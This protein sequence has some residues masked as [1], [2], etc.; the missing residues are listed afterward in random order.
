MRLEEILALEIDEINNCCIVHGFQRGL[1]ESLKEEVIIPDFYYEYPVVRISEQAFMNCDSLK[2][3]EIPNTVTYIGFS[4]FK[5]SGLETIKLPNSLT[6]IR[7]ETFAYCRKLT[8]IILPSSII[9]IGNKAF[10]RCKNLIN[11]ELSANLTNIEDEAFLGCEK[12]EEIIFPQRVLNIGVN[13]FGGCSN[14]INI[15][16]EQGNLNYCSIDGVLYGENG[17]TLIKYPQGRKE[18]SFTIL[19]EVVT[20]DDAA[21]TFCS[22]LKELIIEE[23]SQLSNIKSLAFVVCKI[24]V[25]INNSDLKLTIGSLKNGRIAYDTYII[26]DK[27]GCVEYKKGVT[28]Y[29]KKDD[30]VFIKEDEKYKLIDY[31]G[32]EKTITLPLNINNSEYLITPIKTVNSIIIPHGFTKINE[33]AFEGCDM[34]K[35]IEI[36]NTITCIEEYAFIKTTNLE[37]IYYNGTIADFCK[38]NFNGFY[39]APK[40]YA[41]NIYMLDDNGEYQEV[42]NI[43]IPDHQTTIGAFQFS[44][45][46]KIEKIVLPK[47]IKKIAYSAFIGIYN[48]KELYYDGTI[49]DWCQIEF[50]DEA[51]N[52]L[53]RALKVYMKNENNEYYE[54]TELVIPNTITSIGKNQFYRL[55]TITKI[56]LPETIKTIGECAF[57]KCVAVEEI[58][59][60][61]KLKT[62]EK[63]AFQECSSLRKIVIPSSVE[64][65]KMHAFHGCDNLKEVLFEENS[66]LKKLERYA[67]AENN[68]LE[69]FVLPNSVTSMSDHI[70]FECKSLEKVTV[71]SNLLILDKATFKGC[72]ELKEIEFPENSILTKIGVSVFEECINLQKINIPNTVSIIDKNAFKRCKSLKEITI[73]NA[74]IKIDRSAFS[75]CKVEIN[76]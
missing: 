49:A 52:P 38:I 27:Y 55:K 42:T 31:I 17:K 28:E 14:L 23:N 48:V 25:I 71:S 7:S 6:E 51:A 43:V 47:S 8:S 18:T 60:S 19:K 12:L 62:I 65:I 32:E 37:N 15:N 1:D 46:D 39:S 2:R 74:N 75:S 44:K 50:L 57:H 69:K 22:Y 24:N 61:N 67:F 63:Y 4:A 45:F 33:K 56:V 10:W 40:M 58:K 20:I 76:Q 11:I 26:V 54:L 72:Q 5:D 64:T 53:G 70:F 73:S 3:I 30:F 9:S 16:V 36:P 21:F 34:L 59:L 29:L 68:N 41:K 13:V 35:N 66:K